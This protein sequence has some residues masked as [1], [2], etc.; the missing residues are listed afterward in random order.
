MV[1]ELAYIMTYICIV[2]SLDLL[3]NP[4]FYTFEQLF[5]DPNSVPTQIFP[6]P[7]IY[8]WQISTC[9][10]KDLASWSE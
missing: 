6:L 10:T 3:T 8:K 2:P 7:S 9:D 4:N 5:I 1:H